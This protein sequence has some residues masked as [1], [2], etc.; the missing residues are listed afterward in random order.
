MSTPAFVLILICTAQVSLAQNAIRLDVLKKSQIGKKYCYDSTTSDN[1]GNKVYITY[2]GR[3]TSN[4]G[5]VIKVLTWSRVWGP[6]NHTTGTIY[7][8][9]KFNKYRGKYELGDQWDLPT[10]IEKQQLV[11]IRKNSNCTPGLTS[12]ADFS[13]GIPRKLFIRCKGESGDLYN[14]STRK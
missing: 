4:S 9:D 3:I 6:N 5:D 13:Q 7:L 10:K 2:L 8:F 1:Q 12:K 11:F 14:Y